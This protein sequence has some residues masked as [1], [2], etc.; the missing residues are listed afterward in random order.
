MPSLLLESI[1]NQLAINQTLQGFA[2]MEA[3]SLYWE[4]LQVRL[5]NS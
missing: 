3:I 2:S 1:L 4:V 5:V